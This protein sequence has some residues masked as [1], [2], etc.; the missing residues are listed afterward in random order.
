MNLKAVEI[1]SN[2]NSIAAA[3]GV[4]LNVKANARIRDELKPSKFFVYPD[5]SDS[6]LAAGAAIEALYQAGCLEKT[7]EF[8]NPYMGY[9]YTDTEILQHIDNYKEK[10]NLIIKK[11][12]PEVI[13][14]YL[15]AGHE[16]FDPFRTEYCHCGR[17]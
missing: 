4:M 12:T 6:G 5:S 17:P 15:I 10:Y 14:D 1:E 16:K 7:V 3:G 13:A 2:C 11:G 9:S 8:S